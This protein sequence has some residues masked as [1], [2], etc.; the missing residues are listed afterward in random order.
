MDNPIERCRFQKE[1]PY[2]EMNLGLNEL[3]IAQSFTQLEMLKKK[4][5]QDYKWKIKFNHKTKWVSKRQNLE[6]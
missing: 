4:L 5:R 2:F 6:S 1:K 3:D